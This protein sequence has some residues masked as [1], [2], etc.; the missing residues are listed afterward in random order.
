M[1]IVAGNH[2]AE[3]PLTKSLSID[4]LLNVKLF[5][6]SK[7]DTDMITVNGQKVAI[8]GQSYLNLLKKVGQKLMYNLSL[9]LTLGGDQSENII[10]TSQ[11]E[12]QYR[13]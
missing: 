6:D 13:V 7:P 2:D 5:S 4:S 9:N 1:F 10:K 11:I 3:N 12:V 8:H